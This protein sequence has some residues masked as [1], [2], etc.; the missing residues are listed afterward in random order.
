MSEEPHICSITHLECCICGTCGVLVVVLLEEGWERHN[1]FGEAVG[2]DLVSRDSGY[3]VLIINL[4][5]RECVTISLNCEN[6]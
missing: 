4:H 5:E 3:G 2:P 1:A 6:L